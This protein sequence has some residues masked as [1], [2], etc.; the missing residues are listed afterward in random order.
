MAQYQKNFYASTLY[1]HIRAFYGEYLTDI[2]DAQEPFTYRITAKIL[3]SLPTST[4]KANSAEFIPVTKADWKTR[5]GDMYTK[6]VNSPLEFIAT[7]DDIKIGVRMQNV[8]SQSIEAT[9]LKE[10]LIE[11]EYVWTEKEIL[12]LSNYSITDA[13]K[14][15]YIKFK[16]Y[17]YGDYKV[18]L[19]ATTTTAEAI[20]VNGSLRTSIVN[21]EIRASQD[22]KNW[23]DWENINL[24]LENIDGTNYSLTGIGDITYNSVRYVQGKISIFASDN[25][26]APIVD[27]IELRSE[28]SELYDYD[29]DYNV[30]I[31]FEQVAASVGKTFKSTNKIK[32]LEKI[33]NGTEMTIRS[34]SSRDK[35]FWGP[36]TAPYKQKTKR[37][38]LKKGVTSHSVTI[39]P[40]NEKDK[41]AFAKTL[42]MKSWGTQAFL[43]KDGSNTKVSY[44]FS[45]TKNKQKDPRN[46]LQ[47]ITNPMF[48]E[49]KTIRFSPQPY[50]LTVEINRSSLRGTPV[51]DHIMIDQQIEYKEAAQITDK[52]I[53]AVDGKGKGIKQLQKVN[54]YNFTYPSSANHSAFNKA[55][56]DNAT[57][58][59]SLQDKTRRPTDIV[60]YLK[61][62]ESKGNRSNKTTN[63]LD[64]VYAKV[65]HKDLSKGDTT[66]IQTHYSYLAG[67]VQ[68]LRPYQRELDSNFTPSLLP[69]LRYRYYVQNG[70]PDDEHK[71]I[72]GQTLQ[73]IARMF[74]VT[75]EQIKQVNKNIVYNED[76]SLLSNQSIIIPNETLNDKTL[77]KFANG[78]FYT[79]KSSHNA[80]YDESI[81]KT[82]TDYSS[83]KMD[84]SVP[85]AP[86]KGYVDWSSE[87][88]I[89]KGIINANDIRGEFL[90]TQYNRISNSSLERQ[91]VVELNDTWESIA[92]KYDIDELDLRIENSEVE[93]LEEGMEITIPPN[94]VLPELSPEA[95]FETNNPYEVSIIPD[96]VHKKDGE[97]VDESFIPI[98]TEGKHL[99]LEVSYRNSEILT[100]EMKRGP[101]KNGMD[102][103][104]LSHVIEIISVKSKDGSKTYKQWNGSFGDFKLNSNYVDWSPALSGSVEPAANE[105]Y[106][107]T[108]KR[109]EVDKVKIHLDTDYYEEIGTDIVWRSPEIK[110]YDGVCTPTKDF[111]MELPDVTSFDGY[112]DQY[113]NIGFIIEDNDLWVETRIENNKNKSYLI[114]TLNGKDPSK[115][116]HP[117]INTGFYY[118]REQENY[119]YSEPLKT[120]IDEKELPEVKNIQYVNGPTGIGALLLPKGENIIKDSVFGANV[121]KKAQSLTVNSL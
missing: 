23:S 10:E 18:S 69:T 112:S 24:D 39:G 89:Y 27:R 100:A 4:Y 97:R 70:W 54:E 19:K 17:G 104:P 119:M 103:L 12:T 21:V 57:L 91:Y 90:R 85:E 48:E 36:I 30:E 55:Q 75:I 98:D 60:L 88:K 53:S 44:I 77:V 32:W 66:G 35:V 22:K 7:G 26:R 93:T 1:G 105:E 16:S 81:G 42:A 29:G 37:L 78:T 99:P 117:K 62:E 49:N 102:P 3:T 109:Q 115:N 94:I 110:V 38:R 121:F 45:K 113:K 52:D 92:I 58:T 8:A 63:P 28:D 25:K 108:Y 86:P 111:R 47:E 101:D 61:S 107:V 31:D 95:E 79:E 56:I 20:I 11:G 96:S 59:Y 106:I 46:L 51:V 14:V 65:F 9:L 72:E 68:Y 116:W 87:E 33:P 73:D 40:I 13:D 120:V 114:G 6:K 74:N 118:L 67:R 80:V 82:V 50:F 84:I 71:T 5:N 41:F 64:D 83:E 2:F 76:G 34:S 15:K 43:P